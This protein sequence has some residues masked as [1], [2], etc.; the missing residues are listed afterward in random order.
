MDTSPPPFLGGV[1]HHFS[2]NFFQKSYLSNS[3]C[4]YASFNIDGRGT[5]LSSPVHYVG[6][7][8]RSRQ[9]TLKSVYTRVDRFQ[10]VMTLSHTRLI[11]SHFSHFIR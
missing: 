6:N 10:W 9:R 3:V 5:S 4:H 8:G 7:Y 11:N 2:F 1:I